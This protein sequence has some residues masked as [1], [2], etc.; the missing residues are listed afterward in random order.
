MVSGGVVQHPSE[1]RAG[2]LGASKG[3]CDARPPPTSSEL[4]TIMYTLSRAAVSSQPRV[5]AG[6]QTAPVGR[7]CVLNLMHGGGR[8]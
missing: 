8:R 5:N 4:E 3:F 6:L 1:H 2:M 7:G